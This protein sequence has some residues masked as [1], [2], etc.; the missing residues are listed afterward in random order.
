MVSDDFEDEGHTCTLCR[1]MEILR[2]V[3]EFCLFWSQ[4]FVVKQRLTPL[5]QKLQ[6]SLGILPFLKGIIRARHLRTI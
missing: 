6:S 3:I 2:Q 5:A 1:Y 4:H